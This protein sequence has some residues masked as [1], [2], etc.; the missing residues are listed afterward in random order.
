[1]RKHERRRAV[2][3]QVVSVP[4][5]RRVPTLEGKEEP[6]QEQR[7]K[8]QEERAV[9]ANIVNHRCTSINALPYGVDSVGELRRGGLDRSQSATAV[10]SCRI[11]HAQPSYSP[12]KEAVP[13]GSSMSAVVVGLSQSFDSNMGRNG[14]TKQE[15]ET[16]EEEE[17]ER[18]SPQRTIHTLR[19]SG[20]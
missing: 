19:R 11:F 7:R 12:S 6:K 16:I 3:V 8:R 9:I 20:R 10:C 2:G 13:V 5:Y 15:K 14:N 4:T 17:E 18:T 1:V